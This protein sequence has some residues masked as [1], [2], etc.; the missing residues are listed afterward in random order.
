MQVAIVGKRMKKWSVNTDDTATEKV[1]RFSLVELLE[2]LKEIL[3]R[4]WYYCEKN[5]QEYWA[6]S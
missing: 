6:R 1:F 2:Y 5:F 3:K 4:L